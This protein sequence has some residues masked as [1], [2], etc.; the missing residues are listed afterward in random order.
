VRTAFKEWAVVVDALGRGDQA[1]I[2]RKGGI[3]EGRGGF[4]VQHSRFLLF[5]TLFHQQ[6]ES[7]VPAAQARFDALARALPPADRVRLEFHAQVVESRQLD[8]LEAAQRLHGQHIWRDEVI[9]D[10]FDWGK[11]KH[12][13]ALAVR[14]FR[15][16]QPV[17]LPVLAEY[18]GCKSWLELAEEISTDGSTPVLGEAEFTRRLKQFGSAVALQ[19]TTDGHG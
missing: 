3:R 15:L 1:L 8:S 5:P 12:I 7:V 9:E 14:V 16:P 2:L 19:E 11:D 18:G 10:R 6:R 17:E 4:Q 13:L